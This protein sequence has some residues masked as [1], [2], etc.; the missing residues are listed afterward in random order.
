[1]NLTIKEIKQG[2][3][4]DIVIIKTVPGTISMP[5]DD[6]NVLLWSDD[7]IKEKDG[8]VSLGRN[9]L[10]EITADFNKDPH[11]IA[12]GLLDLVNQ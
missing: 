1:M 7:Y 12:A 4:K 8:V 11:F 9:E 5:G 6:G 10:E 3:R 2:K